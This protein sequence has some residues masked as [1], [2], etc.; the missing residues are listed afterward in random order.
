MTTG[1]SRMNQINK[2]YKDL[3]P[4]RIKQL[5]K[6]L[7]QEDIN[8]FLDITTF[9]KDMRV[10][11]DRDIP[12]LY[13]RDSQIFKDA[14]GLSY[15]ARL[16]LLDNNSIETVLMKNKDNHFTVC[17]STQVGCPVGCL[18]CLTGNMGF[19][20]DLLADEIIDQLRFWIT[21]I[22]NKKLNG[23]ITNI[24]L[25]G[26]GEP[27]LNYKNVRDALNII[28]DNTQIGKNHITLSTIGIIG[29]L[30][31]I[32]NDKEWPDIKIAISLQSARYET[33]KKLILNTEPEFTKDIVKWSKKYLKKYNR[34][35]NF[36]TIEYVLIKNLNDSVD[37]VE[38]LARFLKKIPK[39]KVNLIPF[40]ETGGKF[41]RPDKDKIKEFKLRLEQKSITTTIRESKGQ[42]IFAACGQLATKRS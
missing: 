5:Y 31:K 19:K 16:N 26:M 42:D 18:F 28:L 11:L 37:E 41:K 1:K 40:N 17:L 13:Y 27:L 38:S 10:N 2:I 6:G 39:V 7:F 8:S 20:K 24:V 34:R 21:F 25:M 3:S 29:S 14:A 12:F 9:S 33:R 35:N 15:K 36:L 4:Y 22:K 32:L 30:Y 23:N